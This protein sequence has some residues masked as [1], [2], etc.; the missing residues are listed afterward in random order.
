MTLFSGI[1]AGNVPVLV[2]WRYNSPALVVAG[3]GK[4]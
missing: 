4:R 1:E 3:A 2:V